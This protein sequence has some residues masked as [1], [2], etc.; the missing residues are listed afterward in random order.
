M[1]IFN[2]KNNKEYKLASAY[3]KLDSFDLLFGIIVLDLSFEIISINDKIA[4]LFNIDEEE[5]KG[6]SISVLQTSLKNS[7]FHDGFWTETLSGHFFA[8]EVQVLVGETKLVPCRLKVVKQEEEGYIL[9]FEKMKIEDTSSITMEPINELFLELVQQS[10]DIICFKDG[11]GKWL[12]A[13]QACLELL[14]LDNTAYK[15]KTDLELIADTLPIYEDAFKTSMMSD[16]DCWEQKKISRSDEMI[17]LISGKEAVFDVFKIPSFHKDGSRKNLIV[18]GRDVTARRKAE[19]DLVLS[20]RKAEES[21]QLKSA[22][23]ASM[24]HEL[25]TPLNAVIGFSSLIYLEE[26]MSEIREYS[27][28]ITNNS[29]VL[30]NLIEDI[31]DISLIESG[32]MQVS[33]V[34]FDVVRALNEVYEMFPVEINMMEKFELDFKLIL[35]HTNLSLVNDV[36]RFKQILTNLIRNAIKF[37]HN[38]FVHITLSETEKHIE[39]EIKDSGIGISKEKLSMIFEVFQ[40]VDTGYNRKFGGAGLGLS[41]SKKLA[42]IMGGEIRVESVVGEGSSFVLSIPK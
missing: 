1:G 34:Q 18:L 21:D 15:G 4:Q 42:N 25:R 7:E 27:R 5:V 31:F 38:G 32:Q 20:K 41:I 30:L 36:Y 26:D 22:F 40:Q 13:N 33:K 11:G 23:L 39:V 29:Q 24:S 28:I 8:N 37:T 10:P 9:L 19:S 3:A 12:L 16:E 2:K 17:P 6:K 14:H 35:K